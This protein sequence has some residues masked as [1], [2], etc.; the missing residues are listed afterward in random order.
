MSVSA[1]TVAE[2]GAEWSSAISPKHS[3]GPMIRP[4]FPRTVAFALPFSITKHS[5]PGSPWRIRTVPAAMSTSL[6]RRRDPRQLS[7]AAAP[8]ELDLREPLNLRIAR[9]A[10]HRA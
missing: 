1:V 10:C 7:L 4:F 3:P 2:R 5:W 6:L 9:S 8:E